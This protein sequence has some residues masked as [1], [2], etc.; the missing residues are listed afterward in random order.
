MAKEKRTEREIA[1]YVNRHPESFV[2]KFHGSAVTGKGIPDL[3]GALYGVPFAVEIKAPDGTVSN[4]QALWV[5][6]L[7]SCG[8]V[9]GVVYDLDGFLSL[10]DQVNVIDAEIDELDSDDDDN[11]MAFLHG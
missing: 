8:Y 11:F 7:Q 3:W 4:G 1:G 9:S 10:F 6:R 2:I 5:R